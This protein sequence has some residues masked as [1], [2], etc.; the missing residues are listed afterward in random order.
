MVDE[1]TLRR[2]DVTKEPTGKSLKELLDALAPTAKSVLMVLRDGIGLTDHGASLLERLGPYLIERSRSS[3]WPGTILTTSEAV[4][5]RFALKDAVL[6]ELLAAGN[7]LYDWQQPDLPE[8]P[9]LLREDGSPLLTTIAHERDAFV[10]LTD[11]EYRRLANVP[12]FVAA[13]AASTP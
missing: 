9:C 2:F 11:D 3:S 6:H 5:L 12:A 13:V 4:V 8:D 10:D 7:A 1:A